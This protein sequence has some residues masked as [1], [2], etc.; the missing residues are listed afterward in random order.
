M[1]GK[2]SQPEF[3]RFLGYRSNVAYKWES[4]RTWPT[5][6]RFFEMAARRGVDPVLAL[7]RFYV[8]SP[9]FL[10]DPTRSANALVANLL[11]DVARG[12]KLQD[13]A[14]RAGR[15]RYAVSRW[16]RGETTVRLPDLFRLIEATTYRLLDFV[17][18]FVEPSRLP[19]VAAAWRTLEAARS[20][21]YELPLSQVVLRV[22]ELE[23]Y[24]ALERH[25][26]GWVADRIGISLDDERRYLEVLEAAGQIRLRDGKWTLVATTVLDTRSDPE[27]AVRLRAYW[28]QVAVDR[29]A[30]PKPGTYGYNLF[31]ISRNDLAAVEALQRKYFAELRAIVAE[32]HPDECVVL[33]N[34]FLTELA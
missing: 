10:A 29:M 17:A 4:G 15:S 33:A 16:V 2:R 5:A 19:S 28:A 8:R 30:G 7:E 9:A 21:A 3:S 27:R 26:S 31:S 24:A 25:S 32:S 11:D 22:L 6:A 12:H 1:R 13:L 34:M 20:A 18:C 23:D 14:A